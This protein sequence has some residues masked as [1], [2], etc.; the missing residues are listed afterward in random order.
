MIK[1]LKVNGDIYKVR[2]VSHKR[3]MSIGLSEHTHIPKNFGMLFDFKKVLE[4]AVF[5]MYE[6]SFCIDIVVIG[7]DNTV[8]EIFRNCIP[9]NHT[10]KCKNARYVLEVSA[11]SDIEIGDEIEII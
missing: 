11:N 4:N 8:T 9:G 7:Q 2:Y 3:N 5:N 1:H 10:Y 6:M